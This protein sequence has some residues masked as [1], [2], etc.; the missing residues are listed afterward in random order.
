MTKRS[1]LA[2][3][4]LF[5]TISGHARA[6]AAEDTLRPEVLET[7]FRLRVV[8]AAL[9]TAR[10]NG[11][12]PGPTTGLVPVSS[13]ID[14]TLL[15]PR[16]LRAWLRD[17]WGRPILYWSNGSDFVVVSFGSD[18]RPQFDYAVDPP[19]ANVSKG[20]AGTDPTDDLLVV[21]GV[22]Y[23]GPASQSELLLRAMRELRTTGTAC[24]SFAVDN[25]I[26]PGPVSPI[27]VVSR[28]ETDLTPVYIRQFLE[29]DPWGRPYYFWSNTTA[30]ALV[31]YGVDGQPDYPYA[32]WGQAEFEALDFGPTTRVGQDLV[33]VS[34]SFRQWP[35]I[36]NGP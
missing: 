34:G 5:L 17:A 24:E 31:S 33:F 21:D 25:N 9:D 29:L 13:V 12:Y 10:V 22:A 1:Q 18:G 11:P 4:L 35:A 8:A 28:I 32:T 20:W 6:I 2:A 23:R 7:F 19:Y 15:G 36:G 30:Y 27:D 3:A 16:M 26:Y 14:R